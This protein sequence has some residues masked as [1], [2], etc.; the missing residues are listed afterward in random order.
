MRLMI[1]L[2][3]SALAAASAF[4]A[5]DWAT[6]RPG[7]NM[8]SAFA[9]AVTASPPRRRASPRPRASAKWQTGQA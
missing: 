9:R 5:E 8:R 7:S 1:F 4:A 3:V 2:A 6:R